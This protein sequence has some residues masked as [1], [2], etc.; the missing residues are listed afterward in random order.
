M[1]ERILF[2][3]DEGAVL[4]GYERILH[5][6]FEPDLASSGEQALVM[7]SGSSPYAVV[8]S[9]MRMPGMDGVQFLSRVREISPQ[10]VR[11]MLTGN[12]DIQT[13]MTAVNEGHIFRFL[14][15]PCDP[16]VLKKALTACII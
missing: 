12:A 9:D 10:T 1:N 7:M 5:K 6:D 11:V 2:V 14:T 4:E 8:V 3:D 15:K 16:P 13:A